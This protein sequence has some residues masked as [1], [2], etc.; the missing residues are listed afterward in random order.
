[1]VRFLGWLESCHR[2]EGGAVER[3]F[4]RPKR[5]LDAERARAE[6]RTGRRFENLNLYYRVT[7]PSGVDVPT[8]I[9]A[10]NTLRFVES[11]SRVPRAGVPGI[12]VSPT[13]PNEETETPDFTAKQGYRAAAWPT[14]NGIGI[15]TVEHAPGVDGRGISIFDVEADWVVDHEDL[16]LFEVVDIV[17]GEKY[18]RDET[19]HGTAVIGILG[20]RRNDYGITGI[21]PEA[22][23]TA[24]RA[25]RRNHV[26]VHRAV[27][28][29]TARLAPSYMPDDYN[30]EGL[31]LVELEVYEAC[32]RRTMG[33]PVEADVE[34]REA[35]R[36][37]VGNG[38][39]V[40]VPAGNGAVDLDASECRGVFSREGDTGAIFVGASNPDDRSP[41]GTSSYG[42][43]VDVQGW[44]ERVATS[45]YGTLYPVHGRD[46]RR[47]YT[48]HFGGTSSAAAI[49]AGAVAAIQGAIRAAR[50]PALSPGRMRTVLVET[51]TPQAPSDRQ[52][53]PLPNVAAALYRLGIRIPV[54]GVQ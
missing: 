44:G 52:V 31:I 34:T 53:G 32:G 5:D 11:V 47:S 20:G 26:Y 36:N 6:R 12:Y 13:T 49:V 51:G 3:S 7:L 8:V 25:K 19:Y 38:I 35:I 16:P 14:G 27:S 45:G 46:D 43:R 22:L 1:L 10:L 41:L 15:G 37:A 50:R 18:H 54:E 21:V 28:E 29:V 24:V 42:S 39:V 23:I 9:A 4:D 17:R 2:V 33:A 30:A 48:E 40:V